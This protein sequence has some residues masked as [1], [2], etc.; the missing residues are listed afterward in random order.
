MDELATLLAD[1]KSIIDQ[2]QQLE[3]GESGGMMGDTMKAVDTPGELPAGGGELMG[4]ETPMPPAPVP[5][6][7]EQKKMAMKEQGSSEGTTASDDADARLLDDQPDLDKKEV[8]AIMKAQ[9]MG[10]ISI[11][12]K[13]DKSAEIITAVSALNRAVK[14]LTGFVSEHHAALESII[15]GMGYADMIRK[16]YTTE[17]SRTVQK[18]A[19]PVITGQ[20][21]SLEMIQKS[22][23]DLQS[24]LVKKEESSSTINDFT[25]GELVRKDIG[26][27]LPSLFGNRL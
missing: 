22:I 11:T 18:G 7:D 26:S 3:T 16:S 24:Q 6:P 27:V 8:Q 19:R 9:K 5:Q 21:D 17:A 10:L 4:P 20:N 14:S 2:I 13:V 12:K 23:S 1:A 15:Q 25:R